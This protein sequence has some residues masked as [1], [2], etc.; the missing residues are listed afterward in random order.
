MRG[1]SEDDRVGCGGEKFL[2]VG[3]FGLG[4]VF[5]LE[6]GGIK[7]VLGSSIEIREIEPSDRMKMNSEFA[8]I[9]TSFK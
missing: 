9:K 2:D 5:G 3:Q 4:L 1:L 8:G 6:I 7:G